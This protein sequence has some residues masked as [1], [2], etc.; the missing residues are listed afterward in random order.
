MIAFVE[1]YYGNEGIANTLEK[2]DLKALSVLDNKKSSGD[3]DKT[4]ENVATIKSYLTK[5]ILATKNVC[6]TRCNDYMKALG[7]CWE[8][9]PAGKNNNKANQ[10]VQDN[11]TDQGE[12]QNMYN[13][14][15]LQ[16]A[17]AV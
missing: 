17:G 9:D 11:G 6:K 5:A 10:T 4:T 13:N 8:N 14:G 12:N 2:V 7:E 1:S 15:N 3:G 16:P